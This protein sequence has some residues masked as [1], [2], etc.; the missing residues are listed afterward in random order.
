MK[1]HKMV[2]LLVALFFTPYWAL[3]Q[4]GCWT[5]GCRAFA[6]P[7]AAAPSIVQSQSTGTVENTLVVTNPITAGNILVAAIYGGA[8]GDT[9][10]FTD[11]LGNSASMI[12]SS[13]LA[14]DQ[15]GLA[16]ACA[17]ITTGGSDIMTFTVNGTQTD[18]LAVVYEAHTTHGTCTQDVTAVS[19]N[20]L[21]STSC[22]STAMTTTTANDLVVG[23]CG[24]DGTNTSTIT[25]GS[26]W[27]GGLNVQLN[28]P[29]RPIVMSEY[30][31]GTS[32]GS[33][34]ATSGTFASEEQATLLVALKP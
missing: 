33:F 11:T 4:S 15:D 29:T 5:I 12:A 10:S 26:G 25:A 6:V 7:P 16:V 3:A 9:L 22:N 13:G 24:L 20:A 19:H 31:I 32:P 2:A 30:Q 21:A 28:S 18:V 17:P 23:V 14:T 27:L 1:G 34:T 8:P